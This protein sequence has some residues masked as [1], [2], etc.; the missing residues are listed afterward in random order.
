MK[1]LPVT[2]LLLFSYVL[3][4]PV[5]ESQSNKGGSV[6]EDGI[7]LH[8]A[9]SGLDSFLN[10]FQVKH[11]KDVSGSFEKFLGSASEKVLEIG[12]EVGGVPSILSKDAS[13]ASIVKEFELSSVVTSLENLLVKLKEKKVKSISIDLIDKELTLIKNEFEV[14]VSLFEKIKPVLPT[15]FVS[16]VEEK[17]KVANPLIA[18]L[19]FKLKELQSQDATDEEV[20]SVFKDMEKVILEVNVILSKFGK[21]IVGAVSPGK[22]PKD[23]SLLTTSDASKFLGLASEKL[24]EINKVVGGVP[25]TISKDASLASIVKEFELLSVVTSLENL[26][27]KLKEDNVKSISIEELTL[28]KNEFVIIVSLIEKIKPVLPSDFVSEVEEKVKAAK[29]LIDDLS[30]KLK[31]IQFQDASDEDKA[32]V[33]KDLEEVILEVNVILAKFGMEIIGAASPG[34]HPKDISLSPTADAT[35]ELDIVTVLQKVSDTLTSII[36]ES[37]VTEIEELEKTLEFTTEYIKILDEF[38]E[39]ISTTY[40]PKD[41]VLVTIKQALGAALEKAENLDISFLYEQNTSTTDGSIVLIQKEFGDIFVEVS[42][43]VGGLGTILKESVEEGLLTS[44]LKDLRLS[45]TILIDKIEEES[46]STLKSL[47]V[48]GMLLV[49]KASEVVGVPK[50]IVEKELVNKMKSFDSLNKALQGLSAAT[51]KIAD[52]K[53]DNSILGSD[54]CSVSLTEKTEAKEKEVEKAEEASSSWIS[55]IIKSIIG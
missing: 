12:K 1:I 19:S 3:G 15:D 31:E 20:A 21:E 43:A 7:H 2:V 18:D 13:L 45:I 28:I 49:E 38:A 11:P 16:E 14:I 41:T 51:D 10:E 40:L 54:K 37:K 47:S 9:I 48:D 44:A 25:S 30:V 26:I 35:K 29:P 6:A 23:I 42:S 17:V 39:K 27:V 53:C 33:F 22:H 24:L 36:S 46:G 34:K 5:Q 50:G 4:G 52:E 55:S 8:Q 32:S